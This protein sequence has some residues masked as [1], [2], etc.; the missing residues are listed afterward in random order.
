M[1]DTKEILDNSYYDYYYFID[2]AINPDLSDL[3]FKDL[4]P[5]FS[6]LE[7]GDK[8]IYLHQLKCYEALKQGKNVILKSGTGS[9]KTEAWLL[10]SLKHKI[11]TLA[12]YP[13]LA[14]AN[15]QIKRI[16]LYSEKTG[17]KSL[18]LDANRR[19][20]LLHEYGR[21][22]LRAIIT[23]TDILVTNPALLMNEIKKI[24]KGKPALLSGFLNKLKLVMF[25]EIDFYTPREIALILGLIDIFRYITDSKF[26]IATLSAMIEN[27][28]ELAEFYTKI[29]GKETEIIEGKRFRVENR[30]YVIL[31]KNLKKIWERFKSYKI[32]KDKLASEDQK[33]FDDFEYFR[34]NYFKFIEIANSLRIELGDVDFDPTQLLANYVKDEHV[35][36]VFTRS[37]NK[38]E[39][40]GRKLANI[41]NGEE[42]K[43]VATHHHLINKEER[44]RIEEG[45]RT[46]KIKI[47]ISPRT[48]SQGIDIGTVGRIVHYGLPESLREFYQREGRKGRRMELKFSETIIIPTAGWDRKLL[49]RGIE[50]LYQWLQL[51]IE[52]IIINTENKYRI[53][54]EAILKFQSP[55]L[56]RSLNEE[57]IKLLKELKLVIGDELSERG[58]EVERKLQF[59]EFAPPYGINRILQLEDEKIYLPEISHVD[60][61]EKFQPGC[62]DPSNE[63]IV[64]AH[65]ISGGISR[66]VSAVIEEEIK[67]SKLTKKDEFLPALEEYEEIKY[68][69]GE[70]PDL[71]YDYMT[72]KINS[73]VLCVVHPPR[74]PFGKYYKIPN[75]VYWNIRSSRPRIKNIGD[76][77]IVYYDRKKIELPTA[78]YG[79]YSDYTYGAF[80]ELDPSEDTTSIRIGL[81]YLMIILRKTL[82]IPFDTILYDVGKFGDKKFFSLH[83]PNS[84]GLIFKLDWLMVK[85]IV[86]NYKPEIIDEIL[87]EVVDE[88]TYSDFLS[89]DL[90]WDYAKNYALKVLDYLLL[91]ERM[92]VKFKD[93]EIV[94]P[95][96]SRALKYVSLDMTWL[97]LREEMGRKSGLICFACYD[98]E[99]YESKSFFVEEGKAKN[100]E[101]AIMI[102]SKFVDEDFKFLIFDLN[103]KKELINELNLKSLNF[104]LESL[105]KENRMIDVRE[106]ISKTLDL[107]IAPIE[108]LEKLMDLKREVNLNEV[109]FEMSNS[110]QKISQVRSIYW[111]N[112]TKFLEEKALKYL[113]DNCRSILLLNLVLEKIKK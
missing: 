68:N 37:I 98:G 11:P 32:L 100:F 88:Y 99:N 83:E 93:L 79:K 73:E 97:P 10:Y 94:I 39:E 5:E 48:L 54:F 53:L 27:P 49:T 92:K 44:R 72:G 66:I 82:K 34:K 112:F 36:L 9:G 87:F 26:Q 18:V 90:N 43:Y 51:P 13:T 52:K 80:F 31:G 76:R 106:K 61:V 56:K 28:E 63:A 6:S 50:A 4:I 25:D 30:T 71:I 59:Y 15:D 84:A 46:G 7:L 40:L 62:F 19:E 2:E 96:P 77:T 17:L 70:T 105:S 102:L 38:A 91:K 67:W 65:N 81:A 47:L 109:L 57:E 23:E 42:A 104:L 14:L 41:L 1:L 107:D 95:K 78:T 22:K 101:E 3:T 75:R 74:E 55:K 60:L 20:E 89:K 33:A 58:K 12:I 110:Q 86:E 35:T 85:K 103:S 113:R 45:A 8:R 69:W 24:A 108:E 111:K 29:N 16:N 64:V 21:A